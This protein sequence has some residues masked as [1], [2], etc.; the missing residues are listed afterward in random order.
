MQ[1]LRVCIYV[2]V[3]MDVYVYQCVCENITKNRAIH[4]KNNVDIAIDVHQTFH[5]GSNHQ[6]FFVCANIIVRYNRMDNLGLALLALVDLYHQMLVIVI[7]RPP[8]FYQKIHLPENRSWPMKN[9][10]V[11]HMRPQRQPHANDDKMFENV[12]QHLWPVGGQLFGKIQVEWADELYHNI[13]ECIM[14]VA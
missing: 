9:Q 13:H 11:D 12:D 8:V 10:N 14:V 7:E 1:F 5:D 6:M 4:L 2:S 3:Y